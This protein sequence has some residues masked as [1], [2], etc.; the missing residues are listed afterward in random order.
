[1][2]E[3]LIEHERDPIAGSQAEIEQAIGDPVG[4]PVDLADRV[5]T[6]G[7]AAIDMARIGRSAPR[8]SSSDR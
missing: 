3:D 8:T 5:V 2:N 4:A 1:M 6:P 7:K